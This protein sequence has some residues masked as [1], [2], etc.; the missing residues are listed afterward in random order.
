M[1]RQNMSTNV[2]GPNDVT[3]DPFANYSERSATFASIFDTVSS[4][5]IN[6]TLGFS[7]SINVTTAVATFV[8]P[9]ATTPLERGIEA[10]LLGVLGVFGTI[11]NCFLIANV[12]YNKDLRKPLH[13]MFCMIAFLDIT[14]VIP[15]PFMAYGTWRD[16][17]DLPHWM[18]ISIAAV[19]G[20]GLSTTIVCHCL[21]G[22]NCALKCEFRS[23]LA[24]KLSSVK[25]MMILF[26]IAWV[27][28]F[29]LIPFPLLPFV[30][31]V[32]VDYAP[33]FGMCVSAWDA[34]DLKNIEIYL[35]WAFGTTV[36]VPYFF[37]IVFYGKVLWV[38]RRRL[39][40][41][42]N[43]NI[44]RQFV[45]ACKRMGT[46]FSVF[47]LCFLPHTIYTLADP[48]ILYI[49][50][51]GIR[52][53]YIF[54]MFHTCFNPIICLFTM[55]D[56]NEGLWRMVKC[57]PRDPSKPQ[58]HSNL[59]KRQ[60]GI[61]KNPPINLGPEKNVVNDINNTPVNVAN[62]ASIATISSLV[63]SESVE[64]VHA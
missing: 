56:I 46:L 40:T 62:A 1:D 6:A 36:V 50:T 38:I 10:A 9:Y 17:W 19:Q 27:A 43:E 55:S 61:K 7:D 14:I 37:S 54:F 59:K 44:K 57:L 45:N 26:F 39:D 5:R 23:D 12:V 13:Y 21:I 49:S 31:Y 41:F 35:Y 25:S 24:N 58:R 32:R 22:L 28:V 30:D 48:Y 53:L 51:W 42:D 16:R 11:L 8:D 63:P 52:G 15:C 4:D 60:S 20:W 18:C 64:R 3:S 47:T 2:T 34:P 29:L 33:V